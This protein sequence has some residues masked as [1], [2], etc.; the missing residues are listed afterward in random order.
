MGV[1][2][3]LGL[4]VN[5]LAPHGLVGAQWVVLMGSPMVFLFSCLVSTVPSSQLTSCN[6]RL[7]KA[8]PTAGKTFRHN[9]KTILELSL[10]LLNLA[11][12]FL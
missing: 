3:Y 7:S 9:P 2:A 5:R 4:M 10:R 1:A 6:G 12:D 11:R 8:S